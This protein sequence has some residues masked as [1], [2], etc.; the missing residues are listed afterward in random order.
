MKKTR[1]LGTLPVGKLIARYSIPAIIAM[2]VNAVYNVVDRIFIGNFAGEEALAGLTVAFPVMMIL[3]AFAS[4]IG[5]GGT[6]LLSIKL[7][8]K[9]Y[10]GASHVFGNTMGVG[11]MIT[12]III[13]I[14]SINLE[15][16]LVLFGATA[17]TIAYAVDY[18]R[19]ILFGFI[20]QMFS[21]TLSSS[22]R[23]EGQPLL[24]M[25]TMMLSA[26]TNI[27][28]DYFFIVKWGMGVR[29]AAFATIIGQL[30]GLIL[31]SSFY[32][33]GKSVLKIELKDFLPEF[34][35]VR[36]IFSIGFASFVGVLGVSISM[37]FLNRGLGFYGGTAA[38]TSL[39]AINSLYTLFIMPVLGIQ[40]GI[41]PIIGYNFGAKLMRRVYQ[42]LR[43]GIGTAVVFS[44]LVFII[45]QAAPV[46]FISM[47]M[48]SGS[49][50]VG[51]AVAGLRY[52]ILMLPLLGINFVGVAF[53]QSTARGR[54]SLF[55]SLLRQIIFLIPL[56][57]ILPVFFGLTGVWIATPIADGLAVFLT[58]F[59]LM[60]DYR[61]RDKNGMGYNH[62]DEIK[63]EEV[64]V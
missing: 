39:G 5:A 19:I 37:T 61:N 47:F 8:E 60:R 49:D 36:R 62:V 27:I 50:T 4:L 15:G 13:G 48:D 3:M 22:V 20:F 12:G 56:V 31:L 51:G 38:L 16:A 43:G 42:T 11:F 63:N 57:L 25:A 29:G 7:G 26:V 44:T 18:M 45:L 64:A 34:S 33:R 1:E 28:L 35:I 30:A 53:F 40:Q 52:F 55:L 10:R 23:N 32:F 17:D 54:M 59:A 24:S 21:F 14:L 41:Q 9:D 58:L 2:V 46:V 6:A